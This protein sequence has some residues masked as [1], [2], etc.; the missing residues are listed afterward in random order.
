MPHAAAHPRW[1]EKTVEYA[2]VLNYLPQ[3]ASIAPLAGKEETAY[4]D[5]QVQIDGQYMLIEFKARWTDVPSEA[6]K[7]ARS[8]AYADGELTA[9][10][11]AHLLEKA[12]SKLRMLPQSMAHQLVFGYEDNEDLRLGSVPYTEIANKKPGARRLNKAAVES[13]PR[14]PRDAMAAYLQLLQELRGTELPSGGS[15]V[16]CLSASG[17]SLMTIGEFMTR[18]PSGE[19][20]YVPPTPSENESHYQR[21]MKHRG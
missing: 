14:V 5:A 9:S 21:T 10:D 19:P 8:Q 3:A 1:W 2:F 7:F 6:K 17:T 4:G 11:M 16:V 12:L 15:A 13:L 20:A 18:E